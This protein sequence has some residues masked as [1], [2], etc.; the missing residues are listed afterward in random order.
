M[1]RFLRPMAVLLAIHAGSAAE[2]ILPAYN[3]YQSVPFAVGAGGLAIDTVTYVNAKLKG[4]YQFKL[5]QV[6][7]DALNKTIAD[8][9][10]KGAVLFLSPFFVDDVG[11]TKFSWTAPLM[12]D[13][14]A[15]L[16]L[17]SRKLEWSSADA[18]AGLKF[19]AVKGNRYAGLE[20]RFGKDIVREDVLEELS[21]VKKLAAGKVDLTIMAFSTYR[22]LQ[23]QMGTQAA[24]NS[25]IYLSSKPHLEFERHVFSARSDSALAK[26]LNDLVAGMKN[27]PAWKAILTKYGLD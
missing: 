10:F 24:A 9:E 25:N 3:S 21:N 1:F 6:T 27:D 26:E 7:R 14:N 17:N 20:D 19:G 12:H 5:S 2:E 15:V 11:K 18:L 8:P 23:K 4:K 16:S 13:S 22:F